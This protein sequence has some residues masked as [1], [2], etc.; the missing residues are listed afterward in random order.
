[1]KTRKH[2][3]VIFPLFILILAS[4]STLPI[5]EEILETEQLS[6]ATDDEI[7]VTQ[8]TPSTEAGHQ[9]PE[10][11]DPFGNITPAFR[12]EGSV[13]SQEHRYQERWKGRKDGSNNARGLYGGR[14]LP[15]RRDCRTET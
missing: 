8:N 4:C 14:F 6:P 3:W 2:F 15:G 1:M 9:A 11:E 5:T 12:T 10:C 13:R 7:P